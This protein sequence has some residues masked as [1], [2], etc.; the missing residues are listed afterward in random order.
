MGELLQGQHK[1]E[2]LRRG[3]DEQHQPRARRGVDET[4]CG[5]ARSKLAERCAADG[6]RVERG[7]GGNLGCGRNP[8]PEAGEDNDDKPERDNRA[9]P[10]LRQRRRRQPDVLRQPRVAAKQDDDADQRE[11]HQAGRQQARHEQPADRK[12]GDEAEN[13]QIDAWRNGLGHDGGSR[14]QRH[15]AARILPRSSS[16]RNQHR[17]DRRDIGHLRAGDAGE[18]D[19]RQHH[20]HVEAAANPSDEPFEERDQTNGHSVRLHEV[21]DENE[22]RD[23]EQDEI[24]D[25]ARHLLSEDETGQRAIDKDVDQRGEPQRKADRDSADQAA[26][27]SDEHRQARARGA[28]A[29]EAPAIGRAGQS[30]RDYERERQIRRPPATELRQCENRHAD[31]AEPHRIEGQFQRQ[32]GAGGLPGGETP[33]RHRI[34]RHGR[35]G[36]QHDQRRNGVDPPASQRPQPLDKEG[37]AGVLVAGKRARGAEEAQRHHETARHVVGPLDRRGQHVAIEDRE[38]HHD[39]VGRQQERSDRIDDSEQDGEP[40]ASRAARAR[41][42]RGRHAR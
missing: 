28:R 3:D 21:A 5:G 29:D 1:R 13:D 19:H 18:D 30:Q 16:R 32:A 24:V 7:E 26:D 41:R 36:R 12:V 22:E 4:Q 6:E 11:R 39:E 9:A 14:Q 33:E 27:E 20:D 37:D 34:P 8:E 38:Q 17:A 35:G 25:P 40:A 42:E 10:E 23:R 31:R 15:R 2:R